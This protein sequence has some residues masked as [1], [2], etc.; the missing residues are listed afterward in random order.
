MATID[1]V[2]MQAAVSKS[3]VSRAFSRPG[4]VN[5]ATR[6]RVLEAA[7]IVGY[8][9]RYGVGLASR[10]R[11]GNV[12][13]IVPDVGNPYFQPL[14]KAVQHEAVTHQYPLFMGAGEN[15]PQAE[16]EIARSMARHVDGLLLAS[17]RMEDSDIIALAADLPVVVINREITGIPSVSLASGEGMAQAVEHLVA[18]GHQRIAYL[19]GP[20]RFQAS[21][22][23]L[24]ALRAVVSELNVEVGQPNVE[25]VELGP[26]Q[27]SFESGQRATDLV[28]STACTAVI[29]FNDLTALGL[30]TRAAEL[31]I[32]VGRDLSVIGFDGLWLAATSSPPL[33]TVAAPVGEAGTFAAREL[34]KALSGQPTG[35]HRKLGT[36]LIVRSST[37]PAVPR[38]PNPKASGGR[39]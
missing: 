18:L 20:P 8:R 34:F 16:A 33:T 7:S 38:T 37:G 22:E 39:S 26:F 4:S 35:G 30:M 1:E 6:A 5:A 10:R 12:G 17:S 27:P 32:V 23:R 21:V 36:D 24:D 2:A 9:P 3:T 13:L 28:I 29:A 15:D 14:V 25:V 31:D 19:S 11:T